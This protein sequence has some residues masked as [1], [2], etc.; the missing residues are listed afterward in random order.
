MSRPPYVSVHVPSVSP[1]RRVSSRD[2]VEAFVREI[3]RGR[4]PA[5]CGVPP[6]L[7]GR[8]VLYVNSFTKK[9]WPALRIGFLVAPASHVPS[10]VALKRLSTLGSP[11]LLEAALAEYLQRGYYDA[12]LTRLQAELD[13]R[14]ELC[15]ES[16]RA[17]MPEE[18]RWTT[19][20]GGPTLWLEVPRRVDLS[21]LRAALARRD[22]DVEDTTA[23]FFDRPHL[24]GFRISCAHASAERVR[25]GLE[26]L[27][28]ELE[29]ALA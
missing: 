11:P 10:L 1:G 23:A 8:D 2:V 18:V 22:I 17:L 25:S 16:L 28:P 5:G 12:H 4:L 20:G 7:G 13:R 21:A 9:L 26:V 14:Y 6:V 3:E 29:R 24:H 27:G 15:L 19:P